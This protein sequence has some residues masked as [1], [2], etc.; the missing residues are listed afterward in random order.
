M[1]IGPQKRIFRSCKALLSITIHC[2][3]THKSHSHLIM[4]WILDILFTITISCQVPQDHVF[5]I[6]NLLRRLPQN[7]SGKASRRLQAVSACR[8]DFFSSLGAGWKSSLPKDFS[9]VLPW[10]L[11]AKIQASKEL[12]SLFCCLS[13]PTDLQGEKDFSC[14]Q[15]LK[16]RQASSWNPLQAALSANLQRSETSQSPNRI[17]SSWAKRQWGKVRSVGCFHG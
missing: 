2:I 13:M 17:F 8:E 6:W 3:H 12:K 5:T 10:I 7:V 4:I 14:I 9:S 16:S 11:A 15:L 1:A